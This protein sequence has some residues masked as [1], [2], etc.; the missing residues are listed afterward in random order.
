MLCRKVIK[1]YLFKIFAGFLLLHL[2]FVY[3]FKSWICR[4]CLNDFHPTLD[5]IVPLWR[6]SWMITV[7]G[8]K[9]HWIGQVSGIVLVYGRLSE[10]IFDFSV[11]VIRALKSTSTDL[12]ENLQDQTIQI[13]EVTVRFDFYLKYQFFHCK[14]LLSVLRSLLWNSDK[15]DYC[16]SNHWL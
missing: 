13:P 1:W 16:Y 11:I 3:Y 7:W 6:H 15:Q 14:P 5:L 8:R 10:S 9:K 4:N 2:I 12:I